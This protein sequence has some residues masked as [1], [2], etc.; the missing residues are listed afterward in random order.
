MSKPE[1]TVIFAFIALMLCSICFSAGRISMA[2]DIRGHILAGQ[3]RG[4]WVYDIP[5]LNAKVWH[6]GWV[7]FYEGRQTVIAE[8]KN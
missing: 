4:A 6:Q 8:K 5:P 3:Q 7:K 2:R 1:L